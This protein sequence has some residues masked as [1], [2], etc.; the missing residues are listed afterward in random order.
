MLRALVAVFIV[1]GLCGATLLYGAQSSASK[2][3][4]TPATA[5]AE[6]KLDAAV[7]PDAKIFDVTGGAA[8]QDGGPYS[9][10]QDSILGRPV[11]V[12]GTQPITLQTKTPCQNV[13]ISCLA[14]LV[15]T[16]KHTSTTMSVTLRD[17]ADA[18]KAM[19]TTIT[20]QYNGDLSINAP[21][22]GQ[23]Y[24][25]RA[26]KTIM[27]TWP[28][29]VREPIE[30]DMTSL[31]LSQD[32]WV[33]VRWLLSDSRMR[34]WVDD[35]LLVDKTKDLQTKGIV[36]IALQPESRLAELTIRPIAKSS[37]QFEP[38]GLDGYVHDRALLDKAAVADTALPFGQTVNVNGVPFRFVDRQ[39]KNDA[40]HI[41]VGR[42]LC[43]QGQ[44]DGYFPTSDV[45]YSGC[46]TVDPARIQLRVPN[47]RYDA[48]YVVAGYNGAKNTVP[49]LSAMFYRPGAGFAQSFE[50][51][52]PAMAAKSAP[53]AKPLSV[54]LENGK[55]ANLWLVKV[56]LDPSMLTAFS[57]M[58]TVEVELTKQ[59]RQY[60]S[61]PD[62]FLYGWH[63][64]GLPSGVQVYAVTFHKPD[65]DMS[66]DPAVFGHVWTDPE[67]PEYNV[68]LTNNAASAQTVSL[69][70]KSLSYDKQ[71]ATAP[72]A[73]A[74][75][76]KPGEVKKV[77]FKF[78]NLKKNGIHTLNVTLKGGA[79]A[80]TETRN[81]CRLAKDTRTPIWE[82]GQGP[83]FGFWSYL[84]GHYTPDGVLQANVMLKA[85]ARGTTMGSLDPKTPLGQF[86]IEHKWQTGPN[87]WP[88]S[89][90]WDWAGADQLDPAKVE[91]YKQYT[92]DAF[93]K[94]QGDNP[95]FVTFF[96]EPAISMNLTCVGAPA[97]YYGE[98]Y[99]VTDQEKQ[100]L[101]VFMNTAKVS[102]E[103][104][105]AAWPKTEVLIPYGDP[106]FAVALLRAGF[107]KN[108]IDGS[109]LDM[110]GFERLPEQQLAQQSTHRLY[111]MKN[112]FKKV[113]IENP[114]FYYVEGIFE[115]TE[116]G[117]LTWDEQAER[118]SR[119]TLISL[120]YGITVINSGWFAYDCGSYYGAEH[121]GGCGIQRR[122][123]YEDPKP[124]YAHFAT[125]TRHLE[126]SKFD[127]WL[128]TGS[129]TV[130]CLK[131]SRLGQ[132]VYVLWTIRGTRPVTVTLAKDAAFTVTD[133]MDNGTPAR[134]VGGKTTFTVGTAP[135]YLDGAGEIAKVALG[136][137]DQ[138]DAVAWSRNRNQETWQDGPA[139]KPAPVQKELTIANFGDGTWTNATEHDEIYETNN[140][141]VKRFLGNMTATVTTDPERKGN[142]LAVHLGKQDVERNIM[143]YYTVL[144]PA[145]AIAIPGKAAALGVW[146]KAHSDWG[147]VVYCL[148]DAK[149]ERWI[150]IGT[151]DQWNCNDPHAWAQFNFD[152]WRYLR[153]ELPSNS[154]YD[155]YREFGSTWWG[156]YHGDNIVDLPLTLEKV[157]VERRSHVMYV[158][159]IQPA[160]PED[161][162][163]GSLIAE[164]ATPFDVTPEA[165]KLNQVR[166]LLSGVNNL[167]NPIAEMA[168]NELAPVTLKGVRPPDWG[169]DGTTGMV[170]FTETPE[171]SGY[172]V[173]VAAY[174][175]GRGAVTLANPTKSGQQMY[176]LRPAMKLYLWVTYK[177][178]DGKQS[179]PSNRL[180][181][182][183]VDAFGEK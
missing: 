46:W 127:S 42:S 92:V 145:K 110:I 116:P 128:P 94:V 177:T 85:G 86:M 160:N 125:L 178:K 87:A 83:L 36:Q 154:E 96:P 143:P 149:G 161:T 137:P 20:G 56:P 151:K 88:L 181:V 55:T 107:P 121:Y 144:K 90:Q 49:V 169:Y 64:A 123:P 109:G 73:Q 162:L 139:M 80:W 25:L 126:R 171:A 68:T 75:T 30:K 168:K 120:A 155:A 27:P 22:G 32:K 105:R 59:V 4:W 70:A 38:V 104:I 150:S 15:T 8:Q 163:L 159:D 44:L 111:I 24:V 102:A 17:P 18:N 54:K 134:T 119:W 158:N 37:T 164:Y 148:R 7:G 53:N 106:L 41:D 40:D 23:S 29:A 39:G 63:G 34:I 99:T 28:D 14:R 182:E 180:E 67:T 81:F 133:S 115:P 6:I 97:D 12:C 166:M 147:R 9:I 5:G 135:V 47:A 108:L 136:N 91:A 170:D 74:V 118:N 1:L 16:D 98:P 58:D 153:F 141:D 173:W 3:W 84:G 62:P 179:K 157:I 52:V 35:R 50:G 65:V 13:E 51:K 165:V 183:M 79:E 138:S 174:L 77:T 152:G 142:F 122:I 130:Y 48:M 131:F 101:K 140:F 2:T 117:A 10:R 175:D 82:D 95:P 45:R 66:L 114:K 71:E 33:R 57:D 176:G 69:V 93:R 167:P 21:G 132:P 11:L 31:P 103:A 72:P 124:G 60:R 146:V 89:P 43:R 112:E 19:V 100:T 156:S 78:A 76:L 129:N 113:G 172:Q 61:Y 26:Y